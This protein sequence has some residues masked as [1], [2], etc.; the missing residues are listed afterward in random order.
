MNILNRTIQPETVTPTVGAI[1][2]PGKVMLD[3]G[4]P[5]YLL[6]YGTEDLLRVEFV[7][8]AGQVREEENLAASSV[9]EMLTEGTNLHDAITL[10]EIIDHTG[11]MFTPVVDKDTAGLTVI[12][13][14]RTL[15]K[16]MELAAEVLFHPSFPENEFRMMIERRIQRFLTNRQ[17]T[18][19]VSRELFYNALY[20]NCPYGRITTLED[21][22]QMTTAKTRAFHSRY[23]TPENLYII[24][25]GKDPQRAIPSLNRY[26]S[27]QNNSGK[28]IKDVD[29]KNS[30]VRPGRLF[31]EMADSVQSSIRIGWNG[32]GKDHKDF[33]GLQMAN[34]IL[35]G[36]FGSR[37][38]RNIR[39]EKGYT[40]S[41][42]SIAGSLRFA[43]FITII[44]EVANEYRDRTLEEIMK[45]VRIL[46]ETEPS[47]DEMK[48]VRNQIMGEIVRA[49]DG[50]FAQA[51]CLKGVLDYGMTFDYYR[52][53]EKT[54]RTFTPDKI[55]DLFCTYY[56]PEEAIEIIVGAK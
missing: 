25:A 42:G 35:G 37:L 11:A 38:M 1:S 43:G 31:S 51:E 27:S 55:K 36:Y 26:F 6:G 18:S 5:V 44:T 30:I 41:I 7:F 33:A 47:E 20:G 19:V 53:L 28:K 40:Y 50:P 46:R 16:V 56:K 49:F 3:G 32:V 29:V 2:E 21:Y 48:L 54:V 10:N 15:D 17:K 52:N 34:T 12:T 39:E 22:K 8:D 14:P 24:V 13:L 4:V 9:N 45:E 23:Y